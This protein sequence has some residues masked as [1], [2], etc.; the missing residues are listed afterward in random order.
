MGTILGAE[1][2]S[3]VE[4]DLV[5]DCLGWCVLVDVVVECCT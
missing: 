3:E 5:A 1:F 4:V 2:L